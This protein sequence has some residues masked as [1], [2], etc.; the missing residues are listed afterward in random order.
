[1]SS[2]GRLVAPQYACQQVVP[3][4]PQAHAPLGRLVLPAT[5]GT[6]LINAARP[7]PPLHLHLPVA[8]GRFGMLISHAVFLTVAHHQPPPRPE[9]RVLAAGTGI[10]P[11]PAASPNRLEQAQAL[12]L[13]LPISS[14]GLLHL[15]VYQAEE[16]PRARVQPEHH[17]RLSGIGT[18]VTAVVFLQAREVAV[19]P[20]ARA[21]LPGTLVV[22]AV[23]AQPAPRA[24][25]APPRPQP[26]PRAPVA[27]PRPQP[28]AQ[29]IMLH[30]RELPRLSLEHTRG[31]TTARRICRNVP[32]L[33]VPRPN[34]W[35]SGI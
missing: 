10:H 20:H 11:W 15:P 24:P 17:V 28:L 2:R 35:T 33:A 12:L 34:A 4:P 13:A 21:H 22:N 5:T 19:R 26:V 25:V 29:A 7:P 3:R 16:R 18:R 6:Q 27:I 30:R 8:A 31:A 23:R 9:P 1:M 14:G 32:C